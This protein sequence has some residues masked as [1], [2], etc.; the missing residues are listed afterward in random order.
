MTNWR[1]KRTGTVHEGRE[2]HEPTSNYGRPI[3]RCTPC[4]ADSG[5]YEPTDDPATCKTCLKRRDKDK[6][7]WH[8]YFRRL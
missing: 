8:M 5:A 7:A 4:F 1:N 6:K 2:T 3:L